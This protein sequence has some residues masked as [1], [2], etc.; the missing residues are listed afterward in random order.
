M[1]VYQQKQASIEHPERCEDSLLVLQ[2]DAR[3]PVFVVIDGMG[4]HQHTLVDGELVTGR[5]AAEFLSQRLAESLA[6]LP[7]DSDASPGSPAEQTIVNALE[8]ANR[9]LFEE[10]NHSEQFPIHQRVGAVVTVVALCE[11][12]KRLLAVQVGDTRAYVYSEDE[13][14]QLCYDEDNVQFLIQEGELSEEDGARITDVLNRYDG[15]NPPET[16]GSVT[17]SGRPFELYIAWR[18]FLVGN[19]ALGIP[20]SNVVL[21]ALGIEADVPSPQI[22]RIEVGEGDRLL[23]CSDGVYKNINDDEIIAE[24]Q[25][26]G[27]TARALVEF[28]LARSQDTNNKRRAPDDISALVVG[29]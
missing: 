13:L 22:S 2:K 15:V 12:G 20:A 14:I 7:A 25:K 1:I 17:I 3:A 21:R 5:E 19:N 11:N 18:W 29:F 4:G 26:P 6:D 16:T 8:Q 28:S 27:D 9:R 24:L 10:V 23:L